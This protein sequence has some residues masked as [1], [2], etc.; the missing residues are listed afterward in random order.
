MTSERGAVKIDCEEVKALENTGI[1]KLT[2]TR[3]IPGMQ[4]I[5]GGISTTVEDTE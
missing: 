2:V 3:L 1:I 4:G 5:G